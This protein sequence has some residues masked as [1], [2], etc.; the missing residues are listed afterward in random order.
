M[1]TIE[2]VDSAIAR[3]LDFLARIQQEDGS[4]QVMTCLDP[5]MESDCVPDPSVFPTALVVQAISQVAGSELIR[6]RA[7]PFLL[8]EQDRDG[9]WYHWTKD[10]PL[11]YKLPPDL[12]DTSCV[13]QALVASGLSQP[14]NRG[15][16]LANRD[17]QGLFYTWVTPRPRLV[18]SLAYW[19]VILP[20]LRNFPILVG[21]FKQTSAKPYDIDAVVNANVLYYLGVSA[22]TRPVVDFLMGVLHRHEEKHCD[23]W[24]EN[25]FVVWYAFSR[26]LHGAIPEAGDI[27]AQ[28]VGTAKPTNMLETAMAA[29]ALLYF[30][31]LPNND[32]L[33][34]LLKGQTA[35]GAWPRAALYHGGRTRLQDGT[36]EAPSHGTPYWGS[37]ALTTA[38]CIEAL[39]HW[40]ALLE[41]H[42]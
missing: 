1:T 31:M 4:F 25:P 17:G 35:S 22:E 15:L 34:A 12:D 13:S 36:F 14:G 7:L 26:A 28:R 3:A 10:H 30:G 16:L 37:E 19:R 21:F 11:R 39:S 32:V 42:Q 9:L 29:L 40:R 33:A 20:K 18:L 38:F 41:T 23:K 8:S 5:A 27:I 2:K 6:N 24:Y